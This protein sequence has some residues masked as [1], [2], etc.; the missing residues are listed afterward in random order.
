MDL[1]TRATVTRMTPDP[2]TLT[3]RELDAA[4][5]EHV[6]GL[7]VECEETWIDVRAA[8]DDPG[9]DDRLLVRQQ[10]T[11]DDGPLF[12]YSSGPNAMLEVIERMKAL[13]YSVTLWDAPVVSSVLPGTLAAFK[14]GLR[15]P[16][17]GD[18]SAF[19]G[20][21]ATLPEAVCRAALRAVRAGRDG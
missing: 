12:P 7:R 20:R 19:E 1:T 11:A 9:P 3:G 8:G 6:M 14:R 4:V 16:E 5:A 18:P 2:D 15:P 21:G 13:G 17:L 10:W